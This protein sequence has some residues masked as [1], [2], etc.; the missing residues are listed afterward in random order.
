MTLN[1]CLAGLVAITAPCA[2][3]GM[4]SALLIGLIAGVLVVLAVLFFD[5]MKLDDPVGATSVH[6]VNGVFGTLCVG[7][8][9][10]PTVCPAAAAVKAGLFMGGGTAQLMPQI[11][12]I[13]A[14]GAFVFI[15]ASAT[16]F[17]LKATIGIRVSA[18]EETEGL[19]SAST[20][21]SPTPTS[22]RARKPDPPRAGAVGPPT[23]GV[24]PPPAPGARHGRACRRL[25]P[26]DIC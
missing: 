1:G 9:A 3:V 22:T 7:L 17:L 20:V 4:G 18:A 21:T 8:F 12:G 6:L 14:V 13:V 16:W 25:V 10:D 11:I 23:R 5:K 2:F 15:A 19:D 24:R 26:F